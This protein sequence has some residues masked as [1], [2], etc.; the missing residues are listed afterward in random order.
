MQVSLEMLIQQHAKVQPMYI[1]Y[2][3]AS[4]ILDAVGVMHL[5]KA[6]WRTV[7]SFSLCT[8]SIMKTTTALEY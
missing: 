8:S 7:F 6:R 3:L 1:V 5:Q 4:N 2:H